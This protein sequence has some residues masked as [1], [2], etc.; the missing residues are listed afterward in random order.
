METIEFFKLKTI[1]CLGAMERYNNSK[2][3]FEQ[4]MYKESEKELEHYK[5]AIVALKTINSITLKTT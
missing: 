2:D 4:V 3:P 1:E 5:N